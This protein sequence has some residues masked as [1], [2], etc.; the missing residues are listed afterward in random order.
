MKIAAVCIVSL[1]L[2]VSVFTG[3]AQQRPDFPLGY[4]K[5][6]DATAI[7]SYINS[8]S[9]DDLIPL[10]QKY[11]QQPFESKQV[12]PAE[13]YPHASQIVKRL[14]EFGRHRPPEYIEISAEQWTARFNLDFYHQVLVTHI[15][16]L[17][18]L[19][20]DDEAFEY[21]V[22][23]EEHLDFNYA[24]VNSVYV[25]LLDKYGRQEK[26]KAVLLESMYRNQSTP[27]MIGLLAR[28]YLKE[29]K[30]EAGFSDYL[31]SLKNRKSN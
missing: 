7:R 20:R 21:A 18:Q 30:P 23:A 1:L 10:Y 27:E 8:R 2:I 28:E 25:L 12:K 6:T 15:Q 4:H 3:H 14:E 26:M 17:D 13:L 31:H 5:K 24:A 19:F 11:V 29:N 16:L 22:R 9:Y